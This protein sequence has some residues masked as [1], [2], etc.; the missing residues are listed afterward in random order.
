MALQNKVII[1]EQLRKYFQSTIKLV[2]TQ[3]I[4]LESESLGAQLAGATMIVKISMFTSVA[5]KVLLFRVCSALKQWHMMD[6]ILWH[7]KI[8]PYK[9]A[10]EKYLVECC[11]TFTRQLRC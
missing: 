10:L 11:Y 8:G 9:R 2:T 5:M 1:E 4:I 6:V 3:C 7:H